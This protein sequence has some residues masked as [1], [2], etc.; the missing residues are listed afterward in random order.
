MNRQTTEDSDLTAALVLGDQRAFEI[1]YRKYATILYAFAR[2]KIQVSE[3]CEEIIQEVFTALWKRRSEAAIAELR[4]YLFKMVRYQVIH[5]LRDNNV[6]RKYEEHFLLF[7]AVFDQL[8]NEDRSID[9]A[10]LQELIHATLTKLPA[11]CQEAF[12]LRLQQNLSNG[13]IAKRLNIK[14]ATVE[15]YMI[16]AMSHL[17][18]ASR[19]LSNSA[20]FVL[21]HVP[22]LF[23]IID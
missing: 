23:R 20:M 3:D 8:P 4:P 16:V 1:I 13:E 2:R 10:A 11:R 5:Y 9:P 19:Q 22:A 17:R 18:I 12:Q 14:K 15:R 7:E 6:R 21:L